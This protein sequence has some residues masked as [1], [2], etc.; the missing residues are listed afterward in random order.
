[1]GLSIFKK[2]FLEKYKYFKSEELRAQ[3]LRGGIG[4]SFIQVA[5]R[6]FGLFLG[7]VLA[8]NLGPEGYGV[9][10]YALAIMMMLMVVAEAG[11]P[12]L[13]VREI[14]AAYSQG[15]YGLIRGVLI[16]GAQ[17]VA[18]IAIIITLTGIM[19]L[20]WGADNLNADVYYT[21]LLM[22]FVLPII[23]LITTFTRAL[24]GLNRV[25]IGQAIE[26][27][28]RPFLLLLIIASIFVA[29]P[30]LHQPQYVMAAELFVALLGLVISLFVLNRL[31]PKEMRNIQTQYRSRQW[32][33]SALPFTLIG[34]AGVIHNQTDIIMLGWLGSAEDVGIYRVAILGSSL[35][36]F[37]LQIAN[38]VLAPH[39]ATLYSQGNFIK[40]QRLLTVSARVILSIAIP[41]GLILL[42]T[43][44]D[45]IVWIFGIEFLASY[46]P[47][48]ILVVG[49]IIKISF[50][51]AATLIYMS[52]LEKESVRLLWQAALINILLNAVL[53]PKYGLSGAA[54]AS[55]LSMIIWE[56]SL[57]LKAYKRLGLNS[58]AFAR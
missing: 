28:L 7:L 10:T 8:R 45:L 32:L 22:L 48:V 31:I 47:L 21:T 34:G 13:L 19:L 46:T 1:M 25:V 16:R 12:T 43:G 4:S 36:V 30:T 52:G 24:R 29:L 44:E 35:V 5:N 2:T 57:F 50:G 6:I 26:I 37:G 55:A 14:A 33:K 39:F 38:I 20:W 41:I 58:T 18:F 42:L 40:L 53:I 17:L 11:V 56:G 9:Y 54:T 51:P 23:A 15:E 3:L 49:Q 27:L